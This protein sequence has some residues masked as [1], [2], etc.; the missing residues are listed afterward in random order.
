MKLIFPVSFLTFA[1]AICCCGDIGGI[2]EKI[3]ELQNSATTTVTTTSPDGSS[4][5]TTS[6]GT[7]TVTVGTDD[8]VCG[9]FKT[10]GLTL[11][12][13]FKATMCA[14][15]GD[16]ETLTAQGSGDLKAGCQAVKT[17][18]TGHGWSVTSDNSIGSTTSVVAEKAD[19]RLTLACTDVTGSPT[20]T[21]SITPK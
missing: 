18:A 9:S 7:T 19:K 8:S 6:T 13:G 4:T 3:Q 15:V 20:V 16:T 12:S 1:T 21:L 14:S 11:P 10:D 17:W 2:D 5:T